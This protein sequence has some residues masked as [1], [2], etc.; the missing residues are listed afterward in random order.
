MTTYDCV[1]M[2]SSAG[3]RNLRR[4]SSDDR[5]IASD[6]LTGAVGVQLKTIIAASGRQ[7]SSSR[8]YKDGLLPASPSFFINH[9]IS[10]S[11]FRFFRAFTALRSDIYPYKQ[12]DFLRFHRS[13]RVDH[14]Y[15]KMKSSILAAV[16]AALAGTVMA[17]P[18]PQNTPTDLPVPTGVPTNVPPP[19]PS[20]LPSDFPSGFPSGVPPPPP[21][22]V[23]SGFPSGF[24]SGV[25]PPPPSGLP[26][27]S[28]FP[29]DFPSGAPNVNVN[30]AQALPTR[31]PPT[32]VPPAPPSGAPVP[33]SGLPPLPSGEVPPPRPSGFLPTDL[34][35]PSG[36]PPAQNN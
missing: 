23:P 12:Y 22:G 28:G 9:Q 17:G 8:L 15:F 4:R 24:P 11:Q 33:P 2:C 30:V 19:P 32:G 29:S 27:P 25:P 36:V 5:L 16:A 6:C 10:R 3:S 35:R 26:L 14:D 34:P 18:V 31:V 21:S 13:L 1:R 7:D 20:G